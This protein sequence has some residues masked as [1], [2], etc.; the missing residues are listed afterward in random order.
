MVRTPGFHCR[1]HGFDPRSETK[2][3]QAMYP[4]KKKSD[5]HYHHSR[6]DFILKNTSE[7]KEKEHCVAYSNICPYCLCSVMSDSLK[8]CRLQ[9]TRLL[10]LWDSPGKKSGVGCHFLLQGFRPI[11]GSNLHLLHQIVSCI[12]EGFTI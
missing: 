2:I 9:P 10:C 7:K 5:G 1:G 11:Q 3:L 8:P 4:E 12:A 6:S